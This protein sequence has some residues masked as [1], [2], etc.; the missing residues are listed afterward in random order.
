M[1]QDGKLT[2]NQISMLKLIQRSED[3]GDGWRQVSQTL[4]RHVEEQSHPALTEL[5]HATRRVRLTAEGQ[6]VMRY[7]V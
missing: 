6:T 2:E 5:D 7:A 4:W 3:I 1:K